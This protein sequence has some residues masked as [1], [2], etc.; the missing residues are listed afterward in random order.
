MNRKIALIFLCAIIKKK[1]DVNC[2]TTFSPKIINFLQWATDISNSFGE[3]WST[4]SWRI[5]FSPSTSTN[6]KTMQ[7]RTR[8]GGEEEEWIKLNPVTSKAVRVCACACVRVHSGV[9][10]SARARHGDYWVTW[11]TQY[12]WVFRGTLESTHRPTGTLCGDP[13]YSLQKEV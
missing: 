8:W 6:W 3:F 10:S 4:G 1:K 9:F 2:T 12:C 13:D 5:L 11:I 7:P